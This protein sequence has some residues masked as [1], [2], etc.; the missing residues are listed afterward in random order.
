MAI[1]VNKPV[2]LVLIHENGHTVE[3]NIKTLVSMTSSFSGGII[4]GKCTR[5][6]EI[7]LEYEEEIQYNQRELDDENQRLHL[8]S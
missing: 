2:S 6:L 5:T 3:F 7:V 1:T 8:R 4:G